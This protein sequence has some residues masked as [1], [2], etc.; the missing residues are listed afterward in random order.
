[1]LLV[2]MKKE[3]LDYILFCKE[4]MRFYDKKEELISKLEPNE[5]ALIIHSEKKNSSFKK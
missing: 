3:E 5:D 2:I 1:M 4:K